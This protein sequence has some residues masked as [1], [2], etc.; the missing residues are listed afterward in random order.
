MRQLASGASRLSELPTVV[1]FGAIDLGL[2]LE[3]GRPPSLVVPNG[4]KIAQGQNELT[5]AR[6]RS[7]RRRVSASRKL[8][9]SPADVRTAYPRKQKKPD[10]SGLFSNAGVTV[11]VSPRQRCPR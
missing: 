2:D 3:E 4:Y 6:A 11:A 9:I 1:T 5:S 10:R 8:S 7:S